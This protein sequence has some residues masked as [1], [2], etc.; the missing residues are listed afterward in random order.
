MSTNFEH[1][2]SG[3]SLA[4]KA[5]MQFLDALKAQQRFAVVLALSSRCH[6][7]R[8]VKAPPGGLSHPR[9]P[10]GFQSGD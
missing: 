4:R 5:V 10:G 2:E 9:P 6:C 7:W 8:C 1:A 3:A